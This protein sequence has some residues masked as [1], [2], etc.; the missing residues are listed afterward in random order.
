VIGD[1][2]VDSRATTNDGT[3]YGRAT[4][5]NRRREPKQ[6]RGRFS[7][8]RPPI[9]SAEKRSQ[10]PNDYRL[11]SEDAPNRSWTDSVCS[12]AAAF[13]CIHV[14]LLIVGQPLQEATAL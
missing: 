9:R 1:D 13:L 6:Q 3:W 12:A 10:R 14:A 7:Q 11:V 8:G 5:C 4:V 2:N